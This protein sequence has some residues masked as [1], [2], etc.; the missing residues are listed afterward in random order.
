MRLD[1]QEDD[2]EKNLAKIIEGMN[3]GIR[4]SRNIPLTDILH[5]FRES[6]Q[7]ENSREV[8]WL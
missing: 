8:T 3:K 1:D 6:N 4:G 2:L 7:T 5:V